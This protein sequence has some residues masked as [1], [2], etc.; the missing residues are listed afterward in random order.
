MSH[1]IETEFKLRAAMPLELAQVDAAVREAG[2]ACRSAEARQLVDVYL[3]DAA[4][5]LTHAGIGLRVREDRSGRRIACKT[6][7]ECADGLFVREEH[8]APWPATAAPQLAAELPPAVRDVIEPFV[9]DHPLGTV[10]RITT[11]RDSRI[12]QLEQRDLCE[13]TFDRVEVQSNGRRASFLEVEIEVLDDLP[14]C[15]RLAESLRQQLPLRF[16]GEDK[17]AYASTLLGIDQA[18]RTRPPLHPDVPVGAFVAAAAERHLDEMRRAEVGVR[19]DRDPEHLHRMRV[20]AR[21]LRVLLRS[22]RD[23][24][25]K[26]DVAWLVQHLGETGR[27]LGELRDLDVMLEGLPKAVAELPAGLRQ[28]GERVVRWVR[29]ERDRAHE[30]VHAWLRGSSRLADSNRLERL[31]HEAGEDRDRMPLPLRAAVPP[32]LAKRMANV[33]HLARALPKEMPIEPLHELRIASKRLRYLA[34]EF[35]GLAP[36]D[37]GKSIKAVTKLQQVLGAACDHDVAAARLLEW[38]A[39]ITQASEDPATTAAALGGLASQ[40]ARSGRRARRLARKLLARVDRKKVWRRFQVP[41]AG[42]AAS[43]AKL[44]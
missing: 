12:L 6:R 33:R 42:T 27:Q 14:T 24:W 8:V 40:H 37:Y 29:A 2:F 20:A 17:P 10:L 16:A 39:P 5:S 35:A 38:I 19:A 26:E 31:L 9:I 44:A 41:P 3:D 36:Y 15:E 22:F 1:S 30:R 25:S 13:L 34:E 4:R 32:R 11:Q 43:D 21:R 23:L 28:A 7:G 18:R